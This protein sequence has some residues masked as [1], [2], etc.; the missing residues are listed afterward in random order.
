MTTVAKNEGLL[1]Y[2]SPYQIEAGRDG[3][4]YFRNMNGILNRS[5]IGEYKMILTINQF[6]DN[7]YKFKLGEGDIIY[8][9]GQISGQTGLVKLTPNGKPITVY[10]KDI[11]TF[12]PGKNGSVY[13]KDQVSNELL[14]ISDNGKISVVAKNVPTLYDM[15]VAPDGNIYGVNYASVVKI[16][17]LGI[18]S[19]LAGSST[20][21]VDG[22]GTDARF[23]GLLG[24]TVN[25]AGDLFVAD[26]RNERIRR[27]S[28]DGVVSTLAGRGFVDGLPSQDGPGSQA[29]FSD[30]QD[31]TIDKN[32]VIYTI[33]WDENRIAKITY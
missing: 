22:I 2:D 7:I 24:I 26:S 8:Y 21:Y 12:V 14:L 30:L 31:L 3:S 28:P 17:P 5:A 10:T 27:I 4:L 33:Q 25:K 16:T 1:Q 13:V 19:V 23:D 18:V 6:K 11:G 15:V 32:D 29:T 20:G 9:F